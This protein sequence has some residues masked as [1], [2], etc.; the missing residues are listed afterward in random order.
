MFREFNFKEVAGKGQDKGIIIGYHWS[1]EVAE[2]VVVIIH[3][4]GEYAGRYDRLAKI[5]NEKNIAV[6]SMDLRGHGKSFGKRGH[7]APRQEIL[8]DIDDLIIYALEAYPGIPLVLYGHSMGGNMVLDYR[9]RGLLANRPSAFIVTAPWARLVKPLSKPLAI[10]A[11]VLSKLGPSTTF[12][13][14]IDSSVLGNPKSVGEYKKDPLV[15]G[16]ISAETA[17]D[18]F[19]T[20][21][22]LEEGKLQGEY[23]GKGKPI[24]LIHGK[25]DK[26]CSIE[27]TRGIAKNDDT[28]LMTYLELDGI[29]HEVHNGGSDSDGT[30]VI[31][32]IRDFVASID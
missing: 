25:E 22:M 32:R 11:L 4:I 8:K 26:L 6:V 2:R 24:L 5:F 15:H 3:G 18:G 17:Q 29:Y 31:L 28:G 16:K 1:V 13:S 30:E 19:T 9:I 7:T 27:G 23:N 12:E 14:K 20:G 21:R 10:A